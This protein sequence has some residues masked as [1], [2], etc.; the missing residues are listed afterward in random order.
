MTLLR[1]GMAGL[2]KPGCLDYNERVRDL[3]DHIADIA[4]SDLL[5]ESIAHLTALM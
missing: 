5:T 3:S 2:E 4:G 1:Y